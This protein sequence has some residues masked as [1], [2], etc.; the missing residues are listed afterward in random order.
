MLKSAKQPSMLYPV[1]D[2]VAAQFIALIAWL[3]LENT[4]LHSQK[5]IFTVFPFLKVKRAS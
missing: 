5:S 3:H 1:C 4:R 2:I